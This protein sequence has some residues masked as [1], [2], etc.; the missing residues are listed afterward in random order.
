MRSIFLTYE[1]EIPLLSRLFVTRKR[2]QEIDHGREPVVRLAGCCLLSVAVFAFFS[3][4][5]AYPFVWIMM[6][7][8]IAVI[9]EEMRQLIERG[10]SDSAT[11]GGTNVKPLTIQPWQDTVSEQTTPE[12]LLPP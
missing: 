9:Q 10:K 6:I 5:M 8:S 7:R 11:Q 4:P 3:Y 1:L 2:L 12:T